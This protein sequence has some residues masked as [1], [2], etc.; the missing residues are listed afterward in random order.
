MHVIHFCPNL[1]NL[2]LCVDARQIPIFTT[3][4]D[5]EYPIG[6]DLATLDLRNSPVSNACDAASHLTMLFPALR[7]FCTAYS[8]GVTDLEEGQ[9]DI[10]QAIWLEAE[11]TATH[12]YITNTMVSH[13]ASFSEIHL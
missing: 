3:Q 4:P 10:Y 5:G 2:A 11:T 1:Q 9:V 7:D 8:D 6:L 13:P 12:V